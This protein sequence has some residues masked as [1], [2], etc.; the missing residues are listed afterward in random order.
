MRAVEDAA[1]EVGP[2]HRL[3]GP[4]EHPRVVAHRIAA[5]LA[6]PRCHRRT[7]EHDRT[8]QVRVGRSEKQR[9]PAALAVADH[10][11]L[12]ALGVATHYFTHELRLG[13]GDVRE[14]LAGLGIAAE[15]DEV[16]RVAALKHNTDLAV[17]F[18]PA[19]PGAVPGARI[20]DDVGA[21]RVDNLD[22]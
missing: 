21:L 15:P 17:G 8:G 3:P 16:N 4:P 6:R 9:G 5:D 11:R 22:P 10:Y 2:E 13:A 12:R 1:A 18:E 19:D 7:V 14:G 20:D